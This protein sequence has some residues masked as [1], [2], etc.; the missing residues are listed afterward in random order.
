M[1]VL[2]EAD[3][4]SFEIHFKYGWDN[5]WRRSK[6]ISN[7]TDPNRRLI[8]ENASRR[9][10]RSRTY[11]R[12]FPTGNAKEDALT[13]SSHSQQCMQGVVP[14]GL[15]SLSLSNEWTGANGAYER[16]PDACKH[17]PHTHYPSHTNCIAPTIGQQRVTHWPE[18][19][20]YIWAAPRLARIL[21]PRYAC[22]VGGYF[23]TLK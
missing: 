13:A 14:T 4:V 15:V 3:T 12:C 5:H 6:T 10:K 1:S 17:G 21:R 7:D 2:L 23:F 22:P 18:H 19:A 11:F 9:G 8:G 20:T 16:R